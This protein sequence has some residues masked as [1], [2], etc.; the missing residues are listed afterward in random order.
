MHCRNS[1][2]EMVQLGDACGTSRCVL[3][4]ASPAIDS[5]GASL[6]AAITP[7]SIWHV[8]LRQRLACRIELCV[9]FSYSDQ[10]Y[11]VDRS[12]TIVS[13]EGV[14]NAPSFYRFA[15]VLSGSY[16]YDKYTRLHGG[17]FRAC[18]TSN[19]TWHPAN[20]KR[21]HFRLD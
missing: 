17:L 5:D 20:Y 2:I 16:V 13:S 6:G 11:P 4:F 10:A 1:Q 15:D 3:L 8:L 18:C 9:C 19:V 12:Y 14:E 7:I 21:L